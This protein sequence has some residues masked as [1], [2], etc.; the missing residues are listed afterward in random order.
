MNILHNPQSH[1][2]ASDNYSGIMPEILTAIAMAND[3][4]VGAYGNDPYTAHL[5]TV[6]QQTFGKQAQA[7]PVFNGT[8]ANVLAL[9]TCLP[10]WGAVICADTAHIHTD[11]N[12]APQVV[13][14]AKLWTIPTSD[15]KL[16]P[17]LIEKQ[18]HGFGSEH[19][20]QPIVVSLT[21]STELGTIYT[22]EELTAICDYCHQRKMIVHLD[23]ARLANAAASLNTSLGALTTDVGIDILSLGGTKNGLLFGECVLILNEANIFNAHGIKALRKISLQLASKMRFISAQFIALLEDTLWLKAAQNANQMAAQLAKELTHI[24]GITLLYPTQAN[25]VFAK[26]PDGVAEKL[27]Q[28]T[29]FYDWDTNGTVRFVCSFDTTS[30]H[31]TA[32]VNAIKQALN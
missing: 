12:S 22:P 18:A 1:S 19:R 23:G 9:Q 21:Q 2:F 13:A 31:V 24:S 20:A 28:H 3:G 27:R 25:A 8:G 26:L 17:A 11:E 16:T 30:A 29:H 6:I 5:Q 32:L 7:F 10:R 15:G 4:H 14:G